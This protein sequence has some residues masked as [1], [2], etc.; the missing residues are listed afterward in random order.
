MSAS[1]TGIPFPTFPFVRTLEVWFPPAEGG[2]DPVTVRTP[3]EEFQHID[4]PFRRFVEAADDLMTIVD[5]QGRFVYVNPAA[6]RFF[7]HSPEACLGRDAMDFVHPEDRERTREALE[8]WLSQEGSSKRSLQFEN[9]QLHADGGVRHV[10]WTITPLDGPSGNS[11]HLASIARDVSG[12]RRAER[13]WIESE[14]RMRALLAGMLDAVVTIDSRGVI[15]EVSNS[16]ASVFG[17]PPEML[18]GKNVA[19]LMPEPHRSRH[20]EYLSRYRDTGETWILNTTREFEVVRRDGSLITCELSV[21]RVDVPNQAE[22]SFIGSFRDVTARHRA[23]R[24]LREN[25]R[26]FRALFEQ[27]YQLVGLLRPDGSALELN[28]AALRAMRATRGQALGLPIWDAPGISSWA[29]TG[30]VLRSAVRRAAEGETVRLELD[31]PQRGGGEVNLDAS[32]KP[33]RDENGKV[34]LLILEARNVS[35]L[36]EAQRRETSMLRAL[37]ALGENAAALA[38]EIKNPIAAVNLALRAV[39]DQLGEDHQKVLNDLVARMRKLERT[40]RR[41][42]SL[43]RPVVLEPGRVDV[44][45]LVEGVVSTLAHQAEDR[46]VEITAC[47]ADDLPSVA[48]DE[49]L[50]DEVLTNLVVNALEAVEDGGR[51]QISAALNG[52]DRVLLTVD[53]DGPGIPPEMLSRLF[54]PFQ[55]SKSSGT[56]LGLA[57]CLKIVE[58]HGGTLRVEEGDLGGARFEVDLPSIGGS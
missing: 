37:A 1:R 8:S 19:V 57:L 16:V 20:D 17:Y 51:V 36:K 3:R 47:V 27:E 29:D 34:E 54:Q 55:T 35:A 2:L 14:T 41:T 45:H 22:P 24:A 49:Q 10:Q 52:S 42:L 28:E 25:E 50:L 39:S 12:A 46:E 32:V 43:A 21:S 6:R 9:R 18:L 13:Q 44:S 38:H 56:G 15:R 30:S 33:L 7:G 58:G 40:M 11:R 26:R 5:G 23:E 31:L 53:D 48:G 4:E